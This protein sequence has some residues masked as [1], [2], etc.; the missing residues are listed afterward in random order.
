M[1]LRDGLYGDTVLRIEERIRSS[2][3]DDGFV[4]VSNER[5]EDPDRGI[6]WASEAYV[7]ALV[8]STSQDELELMEHR[9]GGWDHHQD[10]YMFYRLSG[11][12][13]GQT[14]RRL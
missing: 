4:F 1:L 13:T 3:H 6:A 2:F 7:K 8:R 5:R 10:V 9:P 11:R 12:A 14:P